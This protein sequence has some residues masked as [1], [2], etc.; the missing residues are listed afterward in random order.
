MIIIGPLALL[1]LLLLLFRPIRLLAGSILLTIVVIA[2]R[3][4]GANPGEHVDIP[5][6][7][8]VTQVIFWALVAVSGHSTRQRKAQEIAD[9]VAAGLAR[10]GISSAPPATKLPPPR[11][12]VAAVVLLV[13]ILI[14]MGI[15]WDH[16]R[17]NFQPDAAPT[18]VVESATIAPPLPSEPAPSHK[19]RRKPTSKPRPI[20]VTQQSPPP[21]MMPLAD[22][23]PGAEP[24]Q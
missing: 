12:T 10:Q 17:S 9:A 24:P 8:L 13:V 7:L 11:S 5:A 21:V 19:T 15:T 14:I 16:F 22:P 18:S 4:S 20:E 1:C 3:L 6:T 23:S 2:V